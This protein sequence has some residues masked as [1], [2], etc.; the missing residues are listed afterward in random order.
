MNPLWTSIIINTLENAR[1][2]CPHCAKSAVYA[3]KQPDQFYV[4]KHCG[5]KFQEKK[6]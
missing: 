3:Q 1:K 6:K 4:C 2:K 5:R